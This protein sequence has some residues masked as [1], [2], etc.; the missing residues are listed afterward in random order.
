VLDVLDLTASSPDLVLADGEVVIR[1]GERTGALIVLVDGQL[2]VRRRGITVVRMDE[3]GTIVGEL[4]LLLD[5]VASADVVA[6]GRCVVRRMDDAEQTFAN[7]PEFARHLATLLADRL[8]QI[9]TYLTDLQ[10]QYADRD[11]TLGLVPTVLRDLLGGRRSA[12]DP[13]SDRET[14]SPY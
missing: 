5:M 7:N 2:E 1:E 9:S 11:D 10:H 13:G 3:P 14:D 8:W 4:G 6:D 12:V